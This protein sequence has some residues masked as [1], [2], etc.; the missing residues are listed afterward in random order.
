MREF[1]FDK[2][3]EICNAVNL[4]LAKCWIVKVNERVIDGIIVQ[5]DRLLALSKLK[6][7]QREPMEHRSDTLR[8]DE[9]DAYHDTI[10]VVTVSEILID[11]IYC[12]KS[13]GNVA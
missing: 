1:T 2:Q 10:T 4:A 6:K 8:F 11:V 3:I 9:V 13:C 7:W 5:E 12:P